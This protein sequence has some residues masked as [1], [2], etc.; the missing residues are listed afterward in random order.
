MTT[1]TGTE[2]VTKTSTVGTENHAVLG[3]NKK[4]V[5]IEVSLVCQFLSL[6]LNFPI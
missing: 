4:V 3:T 5:N 6:C 2:S 1:G